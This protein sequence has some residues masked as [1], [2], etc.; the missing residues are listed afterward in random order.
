ME[1][2]LERCWSGG[3]G[4]L[5]LDHSERKISTRIFFSLGGMG[6]IDQ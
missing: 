2:G 5:K 6:V 1:V 4:R 3:R